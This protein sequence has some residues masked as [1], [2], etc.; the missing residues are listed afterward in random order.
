MDR[1]LVNLFANFDLAPKAALITEELGV[2]KTKHFCD[3]EK[4][5]IEKICTKLGLKPV[6]VTRLNRLHN[7]VLSGSD[8]EVSQYAISC[9]RTISSSH[10]HAF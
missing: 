9:P 1:D 8:V 2:T 4:S 5:Q 10:L 7:S 6:E 3:V